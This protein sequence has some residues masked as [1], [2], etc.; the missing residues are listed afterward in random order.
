MT[1]FPNNETISTLER[2]SSKDARKHPEKKRGTFMEKSTLKKIIGAVRELEMKKSVNDS[3]FE[4]YKK[5]K[6]RIE[7]KEERAIEELRSIRNEMSDNSEK[8]EKSK[9]EELKAKYE[10]LRDERDNYYKENEEIVNS[11]YL[12][13]DKAECENK[14]I[15]NQIQQ[16][17]T[18]YVLIALVDK[19]NK[20][21]TF[22]YKKLDKIFKQIEEEAE[23]IHKFDGCR[24]LLYIYD[25]GYSNQ[26]ILKFRNYSDRMYIMYDFKKYLESHLTKK[27][28][29]KKFS[30]DDFKDF[31]NW[32]IKTPEQEAQDNATTEAEL[33]ELKSKIK[34]LISDYNQ[35][36]KKLTI[37]Q[38]NYKYMYM[39]QG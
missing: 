26:L 30:I 18:N 23:K 16:Y 7:G 24:C 35:E 27:T 12:L 17:Y 11:C 13:M 37:N 25:D 8:Y 10:K 19:L 2:T 4:F 29:T 33:N 28:I 15:N 1:F 3:Q 38:D 31:I 22:N 5:K 21:K 9:I 14:A 39:R 34:K 6:R 36:R 20:A 32:D